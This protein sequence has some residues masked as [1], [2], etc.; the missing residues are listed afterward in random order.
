MARADASPWAQLANE[1]ADEPLARL[2]LALLLAAQLRPQA[3]DALQVRNA[4][5]PPI[6][7]LRS[8]LVLLVISAARGRGCARGCRA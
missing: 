5:S 3:L 6:D 2:A 1:L 7:P 8:C 4:V